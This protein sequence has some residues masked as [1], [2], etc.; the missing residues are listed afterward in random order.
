VRYNAEKKCI[1]NY[2]S[3]KIWQFRMKCAM[4]QN[5]M[6]VR[7]D[8]EHSDY[9]I[10]SGARK[11]VETWEPT[12]EDGFIKMKDAEEAKKLAE[13]P[14]YKLEH[15][16]ADEKKMI[17]STPVLQ[18]LQEMMEPM[19]DDYALSQK[20]RK[21]FRD[22]KK[23]LE[24]QRTEGAL[25]GLPI[26]MRL[27]PATDED[28]QAAAAVRFRKNSTKVTVEEKRAKDRLLIKSGGIFKDNKTKSEADVRMQAALKRRRID[29]SL[30]GRKNLSPG[31]GLGLRLSFGVSSAALTK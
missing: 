29:P 21:R 8:P 3:T 25:R 24:K 17:D 22:E 18:K 11:K 19:A 13:D 1:G 31:P 14:F 10:Y 27:L 7:T 12:A 30:L 26:N 28:N 6:E 4:C 9:V 16:H 5:W 2:F 20:L 23:E 15:Q